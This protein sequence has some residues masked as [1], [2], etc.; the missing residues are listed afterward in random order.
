MI[1]CNVHMD[2]LMNPAKKGEQKESAHNNMVL[3]I[4]IYQGLVDKLIYLS[5]NKLHTPFVLRSGGS[6]LGL[7]RGILKNKFINK[8]L[9]K[10]NHY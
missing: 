1:G 9:I 5:H 6:S 4:Y 10:C 3:Y 7:V 2:N 8:I